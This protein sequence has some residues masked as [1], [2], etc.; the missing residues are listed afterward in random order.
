MDGLKKF[1]EAAAA[2]AKINEWLDFIGET[3]PACRREVLEQC[4]KDPEA[5]EY[6]V[7]RWAECKRA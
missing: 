7:S 4:A 3:D 2:R 6:Y 1:K 5:R